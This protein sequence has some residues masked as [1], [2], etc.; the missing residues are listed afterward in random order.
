MSS[1]VFPATY[2]ASVATKYYTGVD[3]GSGQYGICFKCKKGPT[4]EGHDGC[5]GT[6]QG[7]IMNACC[8]HG[9]EKMAYIQYWNFKRTSGGV[10]ISGS[11]AITEQKRLI[12]LRAE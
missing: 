11:T 2:N 6:L 9:M 5:L 3:S 7:S 4:I 1:T 10:R 8:G 12:L